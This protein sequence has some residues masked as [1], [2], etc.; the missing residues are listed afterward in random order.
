MTIKH[1]ETIFA[2]TAVSRVVNDKYYI[3]VFNILKKPHTLLY[4]HETDYGFW[5]R[6]KIKQDIECVDVSPNGRILFYSNY[7]ESNLAVYNEK[8]ELISNTSLADLKVSRSVKGG[9]YSAFRYLT[10][11]LGILI[12]ACEQFNV[13]YRN[14]HT[15]EIKI[16]D[17][18]DLD[19]SIINGMQFCSNGHIF[20][21]IL[22][23]S[24]Y[25][26]YN[27]FTICGN[28]STI[29]DDPDPDANDLILSVNKSPEYYINHLRANNEI[30]KKYNLTNDGESIYIDITH[31]GVKYRIYLV[32][33]DKY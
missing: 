32:P 17:F 8:Y 13:I 10:P 20:D 33:K 7:H 3:L 14:L 31:L 12:G 21:D 28:G 9:W 26:L 24:G 25:D 16:C 11:E 1:D 2:A 15:N 27:D 22:E 30:V 6:D 5:N 29:D 19:L 23:K 4:I 18:H